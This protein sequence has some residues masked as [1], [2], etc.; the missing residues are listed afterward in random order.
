[1][2]S[3]A[4]QKNSEPAAESPPTS[5]ATDL[6]MSALERST[7]GPNSAGSYGILPPDLTKDPSLARQEPE[8][9]CSPEMSEPAALLIEK[10][11]TLSKSPSRPS[12]ASGWSP[13][14]NI[15]KINI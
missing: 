15:F 12:G 13:V 7:Q 6:A 9:C 14:C 10:T 8:H 11:T 4:K 5:K 2:R 1:M 3:S